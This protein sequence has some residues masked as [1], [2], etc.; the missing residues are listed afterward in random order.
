M[1]DFFA[2]HLGLNINA[3]KDKAGNIDESGVTIEKY[4]ALLGIWKR[5]KP[6]AFNS[7]KGERI[8]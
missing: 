3:I 1:Y 8:I 6:T 4:D 5:W 7:S 2:R